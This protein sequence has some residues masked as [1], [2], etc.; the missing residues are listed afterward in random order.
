MPT[1]HHACSVAA[2]DAVVEGLGAD[3]TVI[4]EDPDLIRTGSV[5]FRS[6]N[7][8]CPSFLTRYVL[9]IFWR[10]KRNQALTHIS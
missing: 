7:P 5:D 9:I 3:R 4:D 1:H 6:R 2:P 8:T 10:A